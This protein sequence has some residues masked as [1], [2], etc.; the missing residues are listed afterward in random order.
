MSEE[1]HWVVFRGLVEVQNKVTFIAWTCFIKITFLHSFPVVNLRSRI[2]RF[3]F[4]LRSD[5]IIKSNLYEALF[6]L[7]NGQKKIEKADFVLLLHGETL[8]Y[9]PSQVKL[10]INIALMAIF[11][12]DP[13]QQT[14][15]AGWNSI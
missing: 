7:P 14:T 11:I 13:Q 5:Q 4:V 8:Y 6:P 9:P 12:V 1:R 3:S 15:K 2:E 10:I